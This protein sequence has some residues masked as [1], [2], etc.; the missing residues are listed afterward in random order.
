MALKVYEYNGSTF[1]FDDSEAPEGAIEVKA[2]EPKNKS[3]A[4]AN[5][6]VKPVKK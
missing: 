4:P 3:K 5:K 6:A 1:Q 2:A